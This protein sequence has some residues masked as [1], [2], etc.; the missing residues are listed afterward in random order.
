[1]NLGEGLRSLL[2]SLTFTLVLYLILLDLTKSPIK[3]ALITSLFLLLFYSYGH[4][5]FLSRSWM[6]FGISIGRHR[7]LIPLYF[8]GFVLVV[9]LILWSKRDLTLLTKF[10]NAFGVILLIYPIFQLITYQA[11]SYY[12]DNEQM[13]DVT[14][15]AIVSLPENQT[16]PDVYYILVDGYPRSDFINQYFASDNTEF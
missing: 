11:N 2:V 15:A 10:L 7:T 8:L 12:A 3:T 1:M 16:P 6:I 14:S 5:N 4:V 9:W 13:E